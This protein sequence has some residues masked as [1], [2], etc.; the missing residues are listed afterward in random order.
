MTDTSKNSLS[1][2]KANFGKEKDKNHRDKRINGSRSV[3]TNLIDLLMGNI[4]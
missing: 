1:P 3:F 4:K 2:L